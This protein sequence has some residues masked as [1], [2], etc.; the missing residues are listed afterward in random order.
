MAKRHKQRRSTFRVSEDWYQGLAQQS[1]GKYVLEDYVGS[2]NIGHV[3]RA[4]HREIDGAEVAVKLIFDTLRDGWKVELQKVVKLGLIPGVVHFHEVGETSL[5][6][7]GHTG[8]CQ[9]TVWD[10]IPPGEKFTSVS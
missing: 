7:E 9:Y 8:L 2:G 5:T 1:V 10:Y 3:Y 6:H 4:T